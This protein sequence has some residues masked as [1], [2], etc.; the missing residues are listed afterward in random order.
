MSDLE[1]IELVA[2]HVVLEWFAGNGAW[3]SCIAGQTKQ[4]K[5]SECF[6]LVW[7][8][9]IRPVTINLSRHACARRALDWVSLVSKGH[10]FRRR[11][12]TV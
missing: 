6:T 9:A 7:H 1:R 10:S 8:L 5:A 2:S 4:L 12:L 3:S 11:K